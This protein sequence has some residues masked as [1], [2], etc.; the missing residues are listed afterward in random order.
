[1]LV[2]KESLGGGSAIRPRHIFG[3]TLLHRLVAHQMG[4]SKSKPLRSQDTLI[5]A[6]ATTLGR[7]DHVL[8]VLQSLTFFSHLSREQ[9]EKAA[10]CFQ[11]YEV[12]R[13]ET[14]LTAGGPLAF[15]P[16]HKRP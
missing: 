7:M 16:A 14:R 3:A 12:A 5:V 10:M 8:S 13:G 6:N 9:L 15:V 2:A 1:M 11:T 4:C